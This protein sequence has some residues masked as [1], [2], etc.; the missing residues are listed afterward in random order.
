MLYEDKIRLMKSLKVLAQIPER[1]LASLAEFLRPKELEDGASV[2]EEGSIGMSLYFVSS[3]RIRISK[4]IA[5]KTQKDLAIVGPGE[6]FGENA[7][8]AETPRSASAVASGK[9]LL[10]ELFRGDLGRWTKLN[11]QQAVQFFA[12]LVTGQSK[13]LRRTSNELTLHLD[14]D[15]V[16]AVKGRPAKEF[17]GQIVGRVVSHLEG[18][19][20]G[21]AYL[22]ASGGPAELAA[23][24]GEGKFDDLASKLPPHPAASSVW[25]DDSTVHVGLPGQGGALG[26]LVFRSQKPVS[27]DEREEV[28]RELDGLSRLI[29]SGLEGCGPAAA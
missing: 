19:W 11:P 6:F 10:F 29:A 23:S 26:R 14:V 13:R 8:T 16:L 12:E 25:L 2:F 28:G 18:A 27:K 4:R 7:L 1:Q 21:A 3:G 24:H 17:L 15:D 22:Q 9:C 5:G 20:S